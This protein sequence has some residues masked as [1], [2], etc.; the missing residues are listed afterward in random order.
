[1]SDQDR[2]P[3]N[4]LPNPNDSDGTM[5][6]PSLPGADAR[7]PDAV[8]GPDAVGQQPS[9]AGA[10]AFADQTWNRTGGD[11]ADAPDRTT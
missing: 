4:S 7:R 1:M 9:G 10:G 5:D 6:S 2:Y 11:D 8:S 3:L